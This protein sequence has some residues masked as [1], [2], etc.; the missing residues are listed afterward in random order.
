VG[1]TWYLPSTSW[2]QSPHSV[3]WWPLKILL[4]EVTLVPD[5]L[6]SAS[7]GSFLSRPG[8]P[9]TQL[10]ISLAANMLLGMSWCSVKGNNSDKLGLPHP[11]KWLWCFNSVPNSSLSAGLGPHISELRVLSGAVFLRAHHSREIQLSYVFYFCLALFFTDG[12]SK[13]REGRGQVT[14]LFGGQIESRIPDS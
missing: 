5:S 7:A 8:V 14:Q 10:W 13:P 3:S 9:G 4:P 12:E 1:C 2:P 11:D 6:V